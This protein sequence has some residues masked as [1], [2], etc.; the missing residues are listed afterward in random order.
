[1]RW[2][3]DECLHAPVVASLRAE[4]HDVAYAAETARQTADTSLAREAL[5]SGRILLTEDKDFGELAFAGKRSVPG[6]VLLRFSAA[7]RSQKWPA[8]KAAIDRY[9]EALYRSFTVIDKQRVRSKP[10]TADDK[11]A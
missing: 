1:V 3:A 10:L 2:L 9:G 7:D 8:L 6:V 4:G 5:Q 11:R